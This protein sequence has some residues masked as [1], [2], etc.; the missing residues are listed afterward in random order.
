[1]YKNILFICTG[2]SCRSPMA[3]VLFRKILKD[4]FSK[5]TFVVRSAGTAA[6]GGAGSTIEAQEV[7]KRR[8]LD[9]SSHSARM[10]DYKILKEAD[11]AFVMAQ[12]HRDELERLHP[13]F[14]KKVFVLRKYVEFPDDKKLYEN[15][16]DIDDPVGRDV[17]IYEDCAGIL[18]ECLNKVVEIWKKGK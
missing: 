4:N 8:G 11:I 16:F 12:R 9:L 10:V 5:N 17:E 2:N 1:M 15:K 6:F 3:E 7:M 13:D 14:L 18:E